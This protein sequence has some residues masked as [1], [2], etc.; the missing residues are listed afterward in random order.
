MLDSLYSLGFLPRM[1]LCCL[2]M[3]GAGYGAFANTAKPREPGISHYKFLLESD[4]FN[5]WGKLYRIVC[6]VSFLAAAGVSIMKMVSLLMGGPLV[7]LD[8]FG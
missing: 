8:A 4:N 1:L 3:A 5:D 7:D 2:M 6:L